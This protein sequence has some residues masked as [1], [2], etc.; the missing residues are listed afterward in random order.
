MGK[1]AVV[2]HRGRYSAGHNPA[3]AGKIF[4]SYRRDDSAPHALAVAGYLENTF[5]KRNIFIDIDRL[6]AGLKYKHRQCKVMLAII[7]PN[8][9]DARDEETGSHRLDDPE[10]WVRVEIERAS[11]R[12]IPVIGL[13]VRRIFALRQAKAL[14]SIVKKRGTG[15]SNGSDAGQA[16]RSPARSRR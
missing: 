9:I 13:A 5:G 14:A 7:G 8:W 11:A 2:R 6:R 1:C 3:M 10:D 16:L 12:S 4:I 15:E